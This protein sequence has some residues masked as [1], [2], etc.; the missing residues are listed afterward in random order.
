MTPL[1]ECWAS[2]SWVG[3]FAGFSRK[4]ELAGKSE[5]ERSTGSHELSLI[6]ARVDEKITLLVSMVKLDQLLCRKAQPHGR[7]DVLLVGC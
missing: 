1:A 7:E 6:N 5:Q 2:V 3:P 4:K